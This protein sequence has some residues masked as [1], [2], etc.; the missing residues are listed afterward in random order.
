MIRI[1]EYIV[2]SGEIAMR[3]QYKKYTPADKETYVKEYLRLE[4]QTGIRRS[5]YAN[6]HEI[7]VSTF[8]RW[9]NQYLQF[10]NENNV[11]PAENATGSFIVISTDDKAATDIT[12]YDQRDHEKEIRLHYKD[13]VL[14][15]TSDQLHEVME[16]LRLW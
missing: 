10:V 11:I 16:I 2:V 7:A 13:A 14:E 8:K 12:V 9:V 3:G 1:K 4:Q 5:R 6:E 15:F